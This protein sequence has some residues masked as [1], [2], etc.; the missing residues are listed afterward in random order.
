M[1]DARG[2]RL[3]ERGRVLLQLVIAHLQRH[4]VGYCTIL[5]SMVTVALEK[6]DQT[7]PTT[8]QGWTIFAL[9]EMSAFFATVIAY[10]SVPQN[11][12]SNENPKPDPVS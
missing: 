1:R 11:K 10:R 9:E 3:L 7:W 6:L 12:P 5:A 2:Q 8:A 4:V